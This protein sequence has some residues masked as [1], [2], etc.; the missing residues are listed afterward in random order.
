MSDEQPSNRGIANRINT[1]WMFAVLVVLALGFGFAVV[2]LRPAA[3]SVAREASQTEITQQSQRPD[4]QPQQ[5]G[6]SPLLSPD[7][8]TSYGANVG[9]TVSW[10]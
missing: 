7:K 3:E 1:A 5:N 4:L 6:A 9:K 10:V 2:H 8:R